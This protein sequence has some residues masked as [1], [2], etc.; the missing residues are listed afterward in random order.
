MK[1]FIL[2]LLQVFRKQSRM[3]TSYLVKVGINMEFQQPNQGSNGQPNLPYNNGMTP[4]GY[5][6]RLWFLWGAL[7]IKVAISYVATLAAEVVYLTS[8]ASKDPNRLME[9]TKD[10]DAIW[11]LSVEI[12]EAL[13][14]YTTSIE[15]IAAAITI[16]ILFFMF[17]SDSKKEKRFGIMRAKKAPIF[18]YGLIGM[19]SISM[20]VGVN[21]IF[22]AIVK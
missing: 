19:I 4:I 17:R 5:W 10:Q 8:Y 22:T 21:N 6:K 20:C 12:V 3:N 18:K 14:P 2:F 15:G 9:I 13:M 11:E 1:E 16:P 7:I